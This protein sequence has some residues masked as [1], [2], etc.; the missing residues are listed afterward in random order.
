MKNVSILFFL[1]CFFFNCSKD[2]GSNTNEPVTDPFATVTL[3]TKQPTFNFA[4][5][6]LVL[7]GTL[8]L[9]LDANNSGN[10]SFGVCFSTTSNPTIS[11]FV[12]NSFSFSNLDFDCNEN[13]N[14][15]FGQTFYFRAFIRKVQTN[16]VKYGN[17]ITF[18]KNLDLT[19][20]I[21]KDI[22]V[23][24][25][26]VNVNVGSD[27]NSNDERGI[28]FST[29]QNPTVSNIYR[30]D[31]TDGSGDFT[32]NYYFLN[33][34]PNTTYYLRSY[35]KYFGRT[36]Y[37][38]QVS[39]KS[40]GYVGGSGGYVFY[41]KGEI[42]NGWRYLESAV[43]K[44]IYNGDQNWH[45]TWNSCNSMSF[46]NGLSIEIGTGKENTNIIKSN[47]NFTNNAAAMSNFQSLN[48]QTDWFLPSINELKEFH[49]LEQENIINYSNDAYPIL[50]SSQASDNQCY[51]L[52]FPNGNQTIISKNYAGDIWKVRRF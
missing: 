35:V 22:S 18:V 38:N 21:V 6:S 34:T 24:S 29:S 39:F 42:T 27:F 47:C 31:A 23:N 19:T 20:S 16:E 48:N 28:C 32:I 36:Y 45:F 7:G 9:N 26:K 2:S 15:S 13:S 1:V 44:Y 10:Y 11:N 3:V 37:G 49:K 52:Y 51:A 5:N 12:S 25:F 41:D 14:F 8:S 43:S 40:C 50:S 30:Q 46:L 4:N 33:A 17:E